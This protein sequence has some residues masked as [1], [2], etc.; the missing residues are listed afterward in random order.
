MRATLRRVSRTNG[1]ARRDIDIFAP[2]RGSLVELFS[3]IRVQIVN[4][5][6]RIVIV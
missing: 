2:T 4:I 5:L 1:L 6:T 3:Y